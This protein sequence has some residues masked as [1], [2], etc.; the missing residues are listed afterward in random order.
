MLVPLCFAWQ[1]CRNSLDVHKKEF[2]LIP[3][4]FHFLPHRVT[5]CRAYAVRT[6]SNL[7][8]FVLFCFVSPAAAV[9][10][11]DSWSLLAATGDK[12]Q[13]TSTSATWATK[14][15]NNGNSS[16]THTCTVGDTHTHRHIC[17]WT[18]LCL[19]DCLLVSAALCARFRSFNSVAFVVYFLV[20]FYFYYA[21]FM[22]QASPR[23]PLLLPATP[24]LY[25][26]C[27]ILQA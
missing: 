17:A 14:K 15:P 10:V 26:Y 13:A 4:Q 27:P 3:F 25:C 16:H 22:Y 7:F 12:R 9:I 11:L 1:E 18:L 20:T 2:N 8:C 24:C 6:C 5:A 19:T 21:Q 23:T